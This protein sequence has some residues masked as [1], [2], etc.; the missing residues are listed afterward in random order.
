LIAFEIGLQSGKGGLEGLGLL[1]FAVAWW[2]G[3]E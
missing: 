2:I 1:R 3:N